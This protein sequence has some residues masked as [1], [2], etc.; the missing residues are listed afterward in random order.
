MANLT[1]YIGGQVTTDV[2]GD[3]V[4]T[5]VRLISQ[6]AYDA[7]VTKD[8]NTI[9]MTPSRLT[10]AVR[11]TSYDFT[12]MGDISRIGGNREYIVSGEEGAQYT[13]EY[14]NGAA[15][16]T[17]LQTITSTGSN[18]HTIAIAANGFDTTSRTPSVII[19][20]N[21]SSDPQSIFDNVLNGVSR[22]RFITQAAGVQRTARTIT[23]S[24]TQNTN[25]TLTVTATFTG[26][27]I[28]GRIIDNVF[29]DVSGEII[30]GSAPGVAPMGS[31]ASWIVTPPTNWATW[32][33]I[34]S[35][36]ATT[37]HRANQTVAETITRTN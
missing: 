17:T 34:V 8:P 21:P 16:A 9:Y 23:G 7:L 28:V 22:T 37:T 36:D 27:D 30:I 19:A 24:V 15:G 11:I 5:Q 29:L 31:P 2:T 20:V 4:E 18:T 35:A 25:G 1:D 32:V 13:L 6:A 14:A 26:G 10:Q 12:D 3:I 33:F